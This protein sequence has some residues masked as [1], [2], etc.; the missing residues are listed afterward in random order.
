MYLE[1]SIL[2]LYE[3]LIIFFISKI[4]I[5]LKEKCCDFHVI[6]VILYMYGTEERNG[7]ICSKIVVIFIFCRNHEKKNKKMN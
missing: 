1:I 2:L 4:K 6:D 7:K 3:W 5:K